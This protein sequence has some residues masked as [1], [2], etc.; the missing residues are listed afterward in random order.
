MPTST[1]DDTTSLLRHADRFFI[2][3]QWVAPSSDATIEVIDSGTEE[4]FFTVA[5][6]QEA[7][8]ARAVDAARQAFDVGPWPRLT[9]GQRAE[10]LRALG[11]AW[12][13]G[14]KPSARS[15]P[16]SPGCST[17]SPTPRRSGRPSTFELLRRPGRHLRLGGAGPAQP[18]RVRA[19]GAGAGRRGRGHHPVERAA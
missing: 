19:P 5:E 1:T 9:H 17:G 18:A 15:G 12:P 14:P 6:A 3:G 8:M 13:P 10:Y 11:R 16:G 2:G 7:D 4:H